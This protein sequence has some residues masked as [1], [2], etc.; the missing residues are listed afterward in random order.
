[1]K[2]LNIRTTEKYITMTQYSGPITEC[3]ACG[4]LFHVSV[5]YGRCPTC[6]VD[7]ATEE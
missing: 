1:M 5:N 2:I 7:I 4:R 6:E 3:S